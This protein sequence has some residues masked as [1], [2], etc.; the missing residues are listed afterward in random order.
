MVVFHKLFVDAGLLDMRLHDQ[1]HSLETFLLGVYLYSKMVQELW[2]LRACQNYG[3]QLTC[4]F[5]LQQNV[6]Q[7]L[8]EIFRDK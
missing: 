2:G 5:S 6:A 7:Q 4:Y 3:Y 1:C 8:G